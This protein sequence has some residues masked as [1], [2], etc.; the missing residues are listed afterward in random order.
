LGEEEG[1]YVSSFQYGEEVWAFPIGNGQTGLHLSSYAI[2]K[3]GS[4]QAAAG[5]DIFLVFDPRSSR[6]FRGGIER[7]VTKERVR[8]QGCFSA[9]AESYFVGDIDADCDAK[10]P[11]GSHLTEML[12][13]ICSAF[14]R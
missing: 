12:A 8:S 13:L 14:P 5:K 4:A 10:I 1:N 11:S 7:G 3:E 9:S 2:Q 6:I